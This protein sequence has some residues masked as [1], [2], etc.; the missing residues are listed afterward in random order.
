MSNLDIAGYN[1]TGQ[2][3]T[4]C[5]Q[6]AATVTLINTT[7]A[8][9]FILINP[10]G[11]GKKLIVVDAC[12]TYTTAPTAIAT[13]FLAMSAA[14][15]PTAH[16]GLTLL[17]VYGADGSGKTSTNVA[18]AANAST[19]PAVPVYTKALGN[20]QVTIAGS[21]PVTWPLMME[22]SLVMVPGTYVQV[23]YIGQAP[24]GMTS[25]IWAEVPA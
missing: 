13:V 24:V 17:D 2:L 19:T 22:G 5:N 25:M 20:P 6:A 11:S 18:R 3:F 9:G 8:T 1:R 16:S 4:A 7:T 15:N 14:P 21:A 12:F 23:S 10:W